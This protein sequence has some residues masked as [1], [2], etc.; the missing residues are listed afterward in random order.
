MSIQFDS[1][2]IALLSGDTIVVSFRKDGKDVAEERCVVTPGALRRG[3]GTTLQ[4]N[5]IRGWYDPYGP[6]AKERSADQPKGDL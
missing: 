4:F 1:M 6:L 2:S 5:S 3:G